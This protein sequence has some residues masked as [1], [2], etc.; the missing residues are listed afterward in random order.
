MENDELAECQLSTH[1]LFA[2][3]WMLADKEGRF[4]DRPKWI[5]AKCFP[6]YRDASGEDLSTLDQCSVNVESS[7]ALLQAKGFIERYEVAGKAYCQIVNWRKHQSP[8]HKEPESE[9]P[10][11]VESTS[12]SAGQTNVKPSLVQHHGKFGSSLGQASESEN[13]TIRESGIS[14]SENP[15]SGVK[16]PSQAQPNQNRESAFAGFDDFW[17]VWPK[18]AA[19]PE[20]QKAWTKAVKLESAERIIDAARQYAT[21]FAAADHPMHAATFL[22][23]QRW[24]DDPLAWAEPPGARKAT[25]TQ[26]AS[27]NNRQVMERFAGVS[28]G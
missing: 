12:V 13:Q 7:L 2:C 26:Q 17:S 22:N 16:Q 25:F 3:L 21:S 15:G 18:K 1:L 27:S 28:N 9:I 11:P 19:K 23:K 20:A 4:K 24:K 14:E 8:H 10:P 6:Y 5:K